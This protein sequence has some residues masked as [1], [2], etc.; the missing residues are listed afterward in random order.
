M[1]WS[2]AMLRDA[3]TTTII[4][5]IFLFCNHAVIVISHVHAAC[6]QNESAPEKPCHLNNII[7][8][9]PVLE[10][11]NANFCTSVNQSIKFFNKQLS[12]CNWTYT[13][14]LHE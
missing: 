4:I 5:G 14:E 10:L 12:D 6:L 7:N 11:S 2:L 13:Y 3:A 9:L 1:K 8:S